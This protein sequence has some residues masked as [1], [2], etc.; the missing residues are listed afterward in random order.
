MID[1]NEQQII[2]TLLKISNKLSFISKQAKDYGTGETLFPSEIHTI[3]AID[4]NPGLNLTELSETLG[5]SKSATSKFIKKISQSGY[6]I[7]SKATNNRRDVIF[8]LTQKGKIASKGH[9]D[10]SH[11]KLAKMYNSIKNSSNNDIK[12]INEF[13]SGFFNQLDDI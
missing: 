7:K 3:V 1:E 10:F 4:K 13:L 12:I 8:N 11:T 9:E 2:N 6:I 5:V